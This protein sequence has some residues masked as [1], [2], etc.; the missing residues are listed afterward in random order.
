MPEE[1]LSTLERIHTAAKAE[2]L[3][4]GF[5]TASLRNIVKTAG[6]TTGA[7]YGYY[8]SKEELFQALVDEP[9]R[10]LMRE[11]TDALHQFEM[12]PMEQQPEHMGTT[13]RDCMKEMLFYMKQHRDAFHLLLL[14]SEGTRYASM[15]DTLVELEVEAT[16]RYYGVLKQLGHTVPP[17]DPRLEHILV[18]GMMNAYFEI[19][20]HDMPTDDAIRYLEELNDFYTA[21]WTKIM[22]Q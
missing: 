7:F 9:Y 5:R 4:K 1:E 8:K 21:G 2:F 6:V 17:I 13:G 12:L 19:I 16:R 11:Y 14:C 22:G 3:S 15:L 18:T 10:W 20:I